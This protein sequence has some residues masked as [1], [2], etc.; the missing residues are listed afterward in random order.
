[1]A[2][3]RTAPQP[4]PAEP[5]PTPKKRDLTINKVLAGAGAAAT[6]AV[7]GSYFGAAGTVAG[8]ALGSVASTLST[9]LYQHTLDHSRERIVRRIRPS[10]EPETVVLPAP[11][12]P[13]DGDT[14]RL[15]V[16]PDVRAG[17]SRRRIAIY[18]SATVLVFALAL[19]AVTGLELVK[20]SSLT[21]GQEGT[22]VGRVIKGEQPAQQED[23]KSEDTETTS[24]PSSSAKPSSTPTSDSD[25]DS[26]EK[27]TTSSKPA[28]E[29]PDGGVR[30]PIVPTSPRKASG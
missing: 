11:R 6:S 24:A 26:E 29:K 10:D 21:T 9:S 12:F 8:A 2:Q 30:T 4:S 13:V 17:M 18:V 22:S 25:A 1:M 16:E 14:V 15:E 5:E 23:E 27:P 3:Q 7:L 20:G 19:L 28:D